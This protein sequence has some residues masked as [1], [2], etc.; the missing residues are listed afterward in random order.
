[1]GR[2]RE[3]RGRERI[4]GGKWREREETEKNR[5]RRDEETDTQREV[6]FIG[7]TVARVKD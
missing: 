5:E 2:K 4:D 6:F 1:M 3:N 7:L